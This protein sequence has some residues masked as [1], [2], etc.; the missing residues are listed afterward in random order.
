MRLH[1]TGGR[2]DWAAAMRAWMSAVVLLLVLGTSAR[3]QLGQITMI[4][5]DS[6]LDPMTTQMMPFR[7]SR[8]FIPVSFTHDGTSG[9]YFINT[10]GADLDGSAFDGGPSQNGDIDV[11]AGFETDGPKQISV[12]IFQ[13]RLNVTLQTQQSASVVFDSTP[14][15]CPI[16]SFE[17]DMALGNEPFMAG[18]TIITS[19]PALIFR[20]TAT[21][22]NNGS[23]S[24]MINFFSQVDGG[25]PNGPTAGMMGGQYEVTVNLPDPDGE[26]QVLL[27]CED[28]FPMDPISTPNRSD[29]FQIRVVLD[30]EPAALVRTE[31]IRDNM[32]PINRT[33]LQP[34]GQSFVGP[35]AVLIRAE[36]SEQLQQQPILNITQNSRGGGMPV[37]VQASPVSD[38]NVGNRIFVWQFTPI[39]Q[40]DLN[41][42][43]DAQFTTV[44]DLAG[45]ETTDGT[46][47]MPIFVVDTIPPDQIRFPMA[48]G[49]GNVV[50]DPTDNDRVGRDEF[51]QTIRV[52]V[53]DYDTRDLTMDTTDNASGVLFRSIMN[54]P[55][56]AMGD[57]GLSIQLLDPSGTP[58]PGTASIGPP[59]G[60]F[61]QLPNFD[62]LAASNPS[63]FTDAD[64]D[65]IA[66]PVEGIWRIEVGIVDE[67]GNNNTVT[68]SFVVDTTPINAVT[69]IVNVTNP[70]ANPNPLVLG[71][72]SCLGGPML[73]M[74]SASP[75][76]T[77]SSTDATFSVTQSNLQ[78]ISRVRGF[79]EPFDNDG[80]TRDDAA[81]T[82]QITNLREAGESATTDDF[83]VASPTPP[84]TFLPAG[85]LDPRLG[86]ADGLYA[87]RVTPVDDAG[88]RGVVVGGRRRDFVDYEFNLDTVTPFTRRTF[89]QD[90]EPINDPLRFVDAIVVDPESPANG[91]EG[92]GIDLDASILQWSLVQANNPDEVD[93]SLIDG[94]ANAGRL[95]TTLRFVHMP[96]TD[97][98]NPGFNPND[99]AFRVL[100]ELVDQNGFVRSLPT[101][102]SMDGV[103]AIDSL[104]VDL[105][106][107]TLGDTPGMRRGN[108]FGLSAMASL[109]TTIN[110]TQFVFLYDTVAPDL[111][112]DNLED[113]GFI[114]G[115]NFTL[116][117]D[118]LDLSATR[119]DNTMG[120]SGMDR[121]EVLLEV[122]DVNGNPVAGQPAMVSPTNPAIFLP[123]RV[124]PVI[125]LTLAELAPLND[126]ERTD[127]TRTTTM[128]YDG[129]FLST[130]RER[131]RWTID[132]ALPRRDALLE[133]QAAG[134]RYRLTVR[135]F[136]RAGNLTQATRRV[137]VN[138]EQLRAP[139]PTAPVCGSFVNRPAVTFT[140]AG[141]GGAARYSW[142][143]TDPDGNVQ[144]RTTTQTTLLANLVQEGEYS[145]RVASIDSAGNVGRFSSSCRF[146]LDRT[147]PR[148]LS[149]EHM[150]PAEPSFNSGLVDQGDVV[151]TI[152]FSEDIV[153]RPAPWVALDPQGAV[154]VGPQVVTTESIDGDTW[155]GRVNIPADADPARWDGLASVI[156]RHAQ[157]EAGNE[158]QEDR[159]RTVEIDT[160]PAFQ[161]RFF[162][163]PLDP[164]EVTVT[165]LASEDLVEPPSLSQV[166]GAS[167]IDYQGSGTRT[168][169]NPIPGN[170][171]ASFVTLRLNRSGGAQPT[172]GFQ[173]SAQDLDLN[174]SR[175]TVQ[176][177]V[178][179]PAREP[180]DAVTALTA[181]GFALSVPGGAT[182]GAPVFVFPPPTEARD[183]AVLAQVS[184]ALAA[185]QGGDAA[186]STE[187]TDVAYTDQV[188]S[189]GDP[190]APLR[191]AVPAPEDCQGLGL[192]QLSGGTWR[193]VGGCDGDTVRG[194]LRGFGA[195]KL[196]RDLVPPV[197]TPAPPRPDRRVARALAAWSLTDGGSGVDPASIEVQVGGRRVAHRFDPETGTVEADVP[198]GMSR[199]EVQ[200][201][202]T[203]KDR[204][205]NAL[206]TSSY[207]LRPGILG[208]QNPPVAVPNPARRRT[209]IVFDVED[210][211]VVDRVT[212][213][214]FDALGRR[215]R[216]LRF[217]GAFAEFGNRIDWDLRNDRGRPVKNGVYLFRIRLT[218]SGETL[219]RRGKIAVIR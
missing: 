95:R 169:A 192:Y 203:A 110:L 182:G 31:I 154:G 139:T 200:V 26:K 75:T 167:L 66:E 101:D 196:A 118:V 126:P 80:P 93:T 209:S 177:Q 199:G 219:Q 188:R 109:E 4:N 7:T 145:W 115:T 210:P 116:S 85:S 114:G 78:V 44:L 32:D 140:W 183:P 34:G 59:N 136:D 119:T 160:G 128:P 213:Q 172:V 53:E 186:A 152:R 15:D 19:N 48:T 86:I 176:F 185:E 162:V 215:I 37:T 77:V 52:F 174:S 16:Q 98:N 3:A 211:S 181:R 73:Q 72:P 173:L 191:V 104:P 151:F 23:P 50:S 68:F 47:L 33:V 175:R 161:L 54:G 165:M 198:Q 117:G 82:I 71:T 216:T 64:G 195:L 193:W 25:M 63:A 135:A 106:G 201:Q 45:N 67:V 30:R 197:A 113:G 131:R 205:G 107:N 108:Y 42:P 57:R 24:E 6:P 111:T 28:S 112:I 141:V 12:V 179:R 35:T 83:P 146:F 94:G 2:G 155:V 143:L 208:F 36:F 38:M 132:L 5:I 190:T 74:D 11:L 17:R 125:P 164:Y 206:G 159:A 102:G 90:N 41:A 51:P 76:I 29:G 150:D 180:A 137:V 62:D 20:G 202:L 40:D 184:A 166:A 69:L 212:C 156:I 204:G 153:T 147:L 163:S 157:D 168:R 129:A 207:A 134:E 96:V 127:P 105:A 43:A 133:P 92:C 27:Q 148:V 8:P 14:P 10:M 120:G 97:P 214:I 124:N 13:S 144:R 171:R 217:S 58:V 84:G 1:G 149:V 218:G 21:D 91:N 170:P 89:P 81:G 55:P 9:S 60:I 178:V 103:Y 123:A 194:S 61:L 121:V 49:P 65:G 187:L 122:V 142:E 56:G 138:L 46:M 22:P 70:D 79:D 100:L 130:Q 39:Q 189:S 88:N 99:D 158:M 87:V 18:N